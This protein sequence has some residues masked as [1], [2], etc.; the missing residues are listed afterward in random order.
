LL[1]KQTFAALQQL[2]GLGSFLPLAA[3]P[4]HGRLTDIGSSLT[5]LC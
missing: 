3:S 5:A 4:H 2:V 1:R